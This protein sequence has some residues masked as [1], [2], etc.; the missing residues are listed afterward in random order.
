[1]K[2]I[3]YL[4]VLLALLLAG[5]S[6][7]SSTSSDPDDL[8]SSDGIS[9]VTDN[10]SSSISVIP[11]MSSPTSSS[12]ITQSG[13][14]SVTTGSSTTIVSS[15]SVGT[16]STTVAN[17]P[18]SLFKV[19][20]LAKTLNSIGTMASLP[21]DVDLDTI[22]TTTKFIFLLKSNSAS[23]ITGMNF[24]FDHSAFKVTPDTIVTLSSPTKEVD[25]QQVIYVTVEHGTLA[26]GIGYTDVLTG[27]QYGTLTITGHNNDGDFSVTY[28][29]HVYAKRMILYVDVPD[30]AINAIAG[31]SDWFVDRVN[32][33]TNTTNTS[34]Y[35]LR[36]AYVDP[37]S[38]DCYI[39]FSDMTLDTS[40]YL[41]MENEKDYYTKYNHNLGTYTLINQADSVIHNLYDRERLLAQRLDSDNTQD[42]NCV[43]LVND[44][45]PFVNGV[46]TYTPTQRILN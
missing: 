30:T 41:F 5:C 27:N 3:T 33:T 4:L 26:S 36:H 45:F 18:I 7:N 21:Y 40:A 19:G 39:N 14:S 1:M 32:K 6:G 24:S 16:S 43:V 12:S 31:F 20:A 2:K 42:K 37:S 11:E 29:M 34:L 23:T 8:S 15:S 10:S 46:P 28:T 17:A 35:T 38:D 44:N 13:G 25:A 9:S 22:A